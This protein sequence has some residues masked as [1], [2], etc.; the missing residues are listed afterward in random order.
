MDGRAK[1]RDGHGE[2][3]CGT[4]WK[5]F[6]TIGQLRSHQWAA[7]REK[8][9]ICDVCGLEF[10]SA[11]TRRKHRKR[12]HPKAPSSQAAEISCGVAP[13]DNKFSNVSDLCLHLE[14]RHDVQARIEKFDFESYG[15]FVKWKASTEVDF[16]SNFHR[17]TAPI[18]VCLTFN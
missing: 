17:K 15:A 5:A 9:L 16:V 12:T 7:H 6:P 8:D 14:T 2:H 4:C 18:E 11:D 13:C 3:V 1:P 10:N